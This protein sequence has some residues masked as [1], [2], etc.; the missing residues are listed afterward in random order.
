MKK[1]DIES[2]KKTVVN[3]LE[4]N[5]NVNEDEVMHIA[6][7]AV[8]NKDWAKF[9]ICLSNGFDI[10]TKDTQGNTLLHEFIESDY[11]TIRELVQSG[12]DINAQNNKGWTPL[13]TLRKY[14]EPSNKNIET[15]SWLVQQGAIA[16]P[17]RFEDKW[18]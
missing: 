4:N 12:I 7:E 8:L 14:L 6:Y 15:H 10:N 16:I 2:I 13:F 5:Q 17:N 9:K 1:L 18:V 3:S 11:E